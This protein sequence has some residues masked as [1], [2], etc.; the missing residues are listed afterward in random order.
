LGQM[1]ITHKGLGTC[2]DIEFLEVLA[3]EA[4]QNAVIDQ[5]ERARLP[6]GEN[7]LSYVQVVA[8]AQFLEY[9][10]DAETASF[11]GRERID[12]PPDEEYLPFVLSMNAGEDLHQRGLACPVIADEGV[13]FPFLEFKGC[14]M[15]SASR[16]E[17]L[18]D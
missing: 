13:D 6:I 12:F 8:Q 15:Q 7:I 4:V 17:T 2:G 18:V 9:C 1:K 10:A 11:P 14:F 5:S 16:S 3:G